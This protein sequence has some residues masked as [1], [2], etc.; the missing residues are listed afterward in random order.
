MKQFAAVTFMLFSFSGWAETLSDAL[1]RTAKEQPGLRRD[2][3]GLVETL[4]RELVVLGTVTNQVARPAGVVA[5][6]Q[7]LQ[8]NIVSAV[9]S[10]V[11]NRTDAELWQFVVELPESRLTQRLATIAARGTAE[12]QA[13]AALS[14]IELEALRAELAAL[15]ERTS[16]PIDDPSFAQPAVAVVREV[17]RRWPQVHLGTAR[18][19][20]AE[21]AAVLKARTGA[22]SKKGVEQP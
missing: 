11:R 15:T 7:A 6:E 10:I 9:A 22:S 4:N 20:R 14:L 5:R 2:Y 13:A 21:A 17:R 1:A 18:I 3:P 12:Q 8:S 19:T 16:V